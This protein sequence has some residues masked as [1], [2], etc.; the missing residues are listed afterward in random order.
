MENAIADF[1]DAII[2]NLDK[3]LSDMRFWIGFAM[4]AGPIILIVLGLFYFFLA[5]KEANHLPHLFRHGQ[6]ACLAVYSAAGRYGL[7]RPWHCA[8]H[9]GIDCLWEPVRGS[10]GSDVLGTDHYDRRGRGRNSGA[11]GH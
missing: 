5:P 10:G 6:C 1:L 8:L 7:G 9:C 2:P 4:L 11:A 3:M